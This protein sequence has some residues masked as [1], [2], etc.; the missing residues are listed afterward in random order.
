MGFWVHAAAVRHPERVAIEGPER[1]LTYAQL[2]EA[3]LARRGALERD[4]VRPGDRGALA[5][6]DPS[7]FVVALH[8]C[9]LA[10]AAAVPIDLR[11]G[12]G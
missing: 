3:A 1:S 7:E 2:S 11:L 4:G 5:M 8:G 6:A 12:A 9:A 10:G